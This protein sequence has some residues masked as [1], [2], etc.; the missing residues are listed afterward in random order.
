MPHLDHIPHG[1]GVLRG[2]RDP[3]LLCPLVQEVD[4]ATHV[5]HTSQESLC[6]KHVRPSEAVLYRRCRVVSIVKVSDLGIKKSSQWC[7]KLLKADPP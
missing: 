4:A 1:S 3:V 6:Q 5:L 7:W 2:C